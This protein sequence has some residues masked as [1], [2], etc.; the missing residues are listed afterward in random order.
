MSAISDVLHE[1]RLRPGLQTDAATAPGAHESLAPAP[2]QAAATPLA[3][4]HPPQNTPGK[5]E[6]R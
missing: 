1:L 5:E 2:G 3:T 4:S 6:R